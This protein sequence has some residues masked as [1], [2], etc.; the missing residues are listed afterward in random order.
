MNCE[1]I[2]KATAGNVLIYNKT[3]KGCAFIPAVQIVCNISFIHS[4][5]VKLHGLVES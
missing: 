2:S 3:I 1:W 4:F 5:T